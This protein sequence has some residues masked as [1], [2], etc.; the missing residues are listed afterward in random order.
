MSTQFGVKNSW[1][2]AIVVASLVGAMDGL[3]AMGG[4]SSLEDEIYGDIAAFMQKELSS[5][6]DNDV[7]SVYQKLSE[8]VPQYIKAVDEY[9]AAYVPIKDVKYLW[10]ALRSDPAYQSIQLLVGVLD[11][12]V[13]RIHVLFDKK[14]ISLELNRKFQA[15]KLALMNA[16]F[17]YKERWNR[18]YQVTSSH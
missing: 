11:D 12:L 4:M 16:E 9:L 8:S 10:M 14:S 15:L 6:D 7:T 2:L 18:F 17:D 3:V 5:I 1:R 13:K